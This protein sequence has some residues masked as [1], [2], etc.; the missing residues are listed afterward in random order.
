LFD[1][2][3]V[4]DRDEIRQPQKEKLCVLRRGFSRTQ[5]FLGLARFH[6][7]KRNRVGQEK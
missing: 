4:E 7:E 2:E 5:A 6:W 3:L 1:H